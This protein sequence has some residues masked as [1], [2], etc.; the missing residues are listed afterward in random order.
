MPET[1]SYQNVPPIQGLG[2]GL[3]QYQQQIQPTLGFIVNSGK[4][5]SDKYRKLVQVISKSFNQPDML[6]LPTLR[7]SIQPNLTNSFQL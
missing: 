2:I 4:I 6:L 3:R 1:S 7:T 5:G